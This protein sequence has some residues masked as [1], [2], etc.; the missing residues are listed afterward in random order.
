[1]INDPILIHDWHVVAPVS[2]LG[3]KKILP[4]RVLSEDI[5]IWQAGDELFAW[6]DLC[7][8][9]GTRLSL[10]EI[11]EGDKLMCPYHGWTYNTEGRCVHMPAHP[12]QTPSP[13]AVVTT[14]HVKVQYDLIWVCLGEPSTTFLTLKNGMMTSIAKYYVDPMNSKRR[15]RAWSRTSWMSPISHSFMSIF[16]VRANI[17]KSPL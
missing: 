11:Q 6:K 17:P 4:A 13:K 14:Y 2:A 12:N 15:V 7:L 5:V 1:M 8:H 10:G 9:R 16:S 3:E